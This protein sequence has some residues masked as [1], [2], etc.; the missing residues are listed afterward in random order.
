M[1][2]NF[3]IRQF[4]NVRLAQPRNLADGGISLKVA[5]TL[6]FQWTQVE[7]NS[8]KKNIIA[9]TGGRV[10]FFKIEVLL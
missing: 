5:M 6:I 1:V 8:E 9:E 4:R 10:Q 3:V 2:S 7:G